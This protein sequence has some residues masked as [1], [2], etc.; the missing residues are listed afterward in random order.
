M[1]V[2]HFIPRDECGLHDPS[3]E[4]SCGPFPVRQELLRENLATDYDLVYE[5]PAY[6]L[7]TDDFL[8][9]EEPDPVV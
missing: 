9:E 8:V 5:H 1:T 2:G 3:S 4:C 6:G 7:P